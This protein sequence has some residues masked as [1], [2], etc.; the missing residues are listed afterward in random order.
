[1]NITDQSH[2]PML[3]VINVGSSTIKMAVY[4]VDKQQLQLNEK[5]STKR[6]VSLFIERF[7]QLISG[8]NGKI[9]AVAHR[10]VALDSTIQSPVVI[11]E[12]V[13]TRLIETE[14]LAPL[15]NPFAISVIK[16]CQAIFAQHVLQTIHSD[17]EFF[18]DLPDIASDYALSKTL[19]AK[20]NINKKGFHGFAHRSMLHILRE[21]KLKDSGKHQKIITIQLGSGCSICAINSDKPVDIS[22]GSSTNEGLIMSNRSGDVDSE[23]ML[24]IQHEL[25]LNADQVMRELNESSGMLGLTGY[26]GDMKT[27]TQS[28]SKYDKEAIEKYCYRI[29]KYIGAYVAILGGLDC[30]IIGGGVGAN[31]SLIRTKILSNWQ[32]LN[33]IS[34]EKSIR[35]VNKRLSD[36]S[37]TKSNVKIFICS[38]DEEHLIADDAFKLISQIYS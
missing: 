38:I 34:D 3:V 24:K 8:T 29:R 15:H 12:K 2:S 13:M 17:S 33:M 9:I 26:S 37:H 11:S 4:Q 6:D 21:A 22:M 32:W 28:D 30:L 23:S 25:S 18:K 10:F 35:A 1:M 31:S 14:D 27:I 16:I 19:T 20:R 5:C 36:I 7:K